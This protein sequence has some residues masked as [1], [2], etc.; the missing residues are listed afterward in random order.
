MFG[1]QRFFSQTFLRDSFNLIWRKLFKFFFSS[2]ENILNFKNLALIFYSSFQVFY[3]NSFNLSH[4]NLTSLIHCLHLAYYIVHPLLVLGKYTFF[5][6]NFLF[7]LYCIIS[8]I[9]VLYE[10]NVK[11]YLTIFSNN[12]TILKVFIF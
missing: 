10:Y 6:K 1:E 9:L 12:L 3:K 7:N 5:T 2:K 4:Y 11:F 8:F